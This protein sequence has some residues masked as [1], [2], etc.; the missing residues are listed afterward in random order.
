VNALDQV[1]ADFLFALGTLRQARCRSELRLEEIPAP[2]RLAPF[3]VALGAEVLV[4]GDAGGSVHGPAAAALAPAAG[5][6]DVELATGRFILLHD[7]DG[8]AV[9]DGE[10][11]IVTYIRAQLEPEMGNDEMLGS[12]AWTW[13]VEALD[14]HAAPYRSAGGTATRVLSESFGTLADRP[15]SIDIELRASWTPASADITSHLEAWSDMVCTFA[16][17]PPLP[18]GVSPLPRRR[19]EQP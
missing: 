17:L 11:R 15:N 14:N 6:D 12:V 18:E 3:A 5:S 16:G 7:P 2:S 13:L 1:P 10:F 9:W 8:S 19:R 4:P